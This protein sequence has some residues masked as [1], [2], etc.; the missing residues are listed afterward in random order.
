MGAD[1]QGRPFLHS[2]SKPLIVL[3]DLAKDFG[4]KTAVNKISMS[5]ASGEIFGFLGPNGAGKTTTIRIL[6]GLSKPSGG[7]A[8]IGGLD[9]WKDRFRIRSKFGYVSQRFSLYTDLTVGEN[10]RFFAGAYRVPRDRFE[11]QVSRMLKEMDLEAYADTRAGKLSGGYKQL[12]AIACALV[13][14]PALLFLDE[15]TAGLDPVHRQ[16][17]WDLLYTVTQS[18]TTVFVTTHYMD[19]AERCSEVG[20]IQ[21]GRLVAKDKPHYL[22]KRLGGDMLEV[23]VEPAM[24]A[25]LELRKYPGI[26]GVDL[27]SGRLRIHAENPQALLKQWQQHWPFQRLKLLG[28]AWVEPDMEDVFYACVQGYDLKRQTQATGAAAI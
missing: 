21:S 10:L 19:E 27:R 25:V 24:S 6:C 20:F 22:K 7:S 16:Q 18:G 23:H 2:T 13:H 15:P 1:A 8:S 11:Q 3:Q 12:L 26:L 5:I 17:I 14:E 4:R 28:S 9:V